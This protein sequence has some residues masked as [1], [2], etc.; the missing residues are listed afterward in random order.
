[1]TE[2]SYNVFQGAGKLASE[3]D[4]IRDANGYTNPNL[5]R[6]VDAK[7]PEPESKEV[8]PRTYMFNRQGL[9]QLQVTKK[10]FNDEDGQESEIP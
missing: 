8:K 3:E 9:N 10:Y 5:H 2:H 1:M 7:Q 6:R 4:K